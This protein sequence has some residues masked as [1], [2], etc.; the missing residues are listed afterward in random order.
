YIGLGASNTDYW[1]LTYS[2]TG[3][4]AG[5]TINSSTGLISGAIAPN[6]WRNTAYTVTVTATD[7]S[8]D[9]SDSKT[10]S[11]TVTRPSVLLSNP[12]DQT[13]Q[14][15]DTVSLST[16]SAATAGHN[17]KYVAVGLPAGLTINEDTGAITGTI[18]DDDGD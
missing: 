18:D 16:S 8:S 14:G 10:F 15:L 4:P 13:N 11:W 1:P 6:A 3:L 7:S 2:A 12:G 5:A 17:F 9:I